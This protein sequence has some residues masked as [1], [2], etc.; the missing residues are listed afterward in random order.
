VRQSK[1]TASQKRIDVITAVRA[2]RENVT[3]AWNSLVSYQLSLSSIAVQLSASKLSLDGVRQEYQVG[4]RTTID[5]LNA[6]QALL[7]VQITNVSAKHDQIVGSYL[8]LASMGRLTAENLGLGNLYDP[9][10]NYDNVRGKWFGT[11]AET[12]K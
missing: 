11:G 5:V 9:T 2:V 10:E 8:L 1:Q 3:N 4:S 6:Q 12:V 7:N